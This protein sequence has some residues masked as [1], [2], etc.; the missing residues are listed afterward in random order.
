MLLHRLCVCGEVSQIIDRDHSNPRITVI[1]RER[2]AHW[3]CTIGVP[4]AQ[5]GQRSCVW[6]TTTG[7]LLYDL[8]IW[9]LIHRF[10]RYPIRQWVVV[11]SQWE[12]IGRYRWCGHPP[13]S[14]RP[15][16]IVASH[17]LFEWSLQ[18][19]LPSSKEGRVC[20][21]IEPVIAMDDVPW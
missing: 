14:H 2:T 11:A 16:V 7:Q 6:Q 5:H 8:R 20:P 19:I 10:S 3:Y 17:W 9:T 12:G 18:T 1:V 13:T 4:P 15:P 21:A